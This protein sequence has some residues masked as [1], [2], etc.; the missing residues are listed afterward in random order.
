MNTEEERSDAPGSEASNESQWPALSGVTPYEVARLAIELS[1]NPEVVTENPTW[2][3]RSLLAVNLLE[4]AQ[5]QLA[6]RQRSPFNL[7]FNEPLAHW[8]IERDRRISFYDQLR[9][10]VHWK[11][12]SQTALVPLA[13]VARR[14][15]GSKRR[16]QAM[17][18]LELVLCSL[19][20]FDGLPGY[21]RQ[22][23]ESWLK[24]ASVP[25]GH[26]EFLTGLYADWFTKFYP[27][28]LAKAKGEMGGRAKA[29]KQRNPQPSGEVRTSER[30]NGSKSV[31]AQ[32]KRLGHQKRGSFRK[33]PLDS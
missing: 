22:D 23:A 14:I 18:Q 8:R 29:E 11:E 15:T 9:H 12:R 17:N 26:I 27:S 6:E 5:E 2:G 4:L 20:R 7:F 28:A 30:T 3:D 25:Q 16:K 21:V 19:A 13:K 1:K 31:R 33:K 24:S 10:E 32:Q